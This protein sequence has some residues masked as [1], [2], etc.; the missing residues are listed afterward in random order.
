M[1]HSSQPRAVHLIKPDTPAPVEAPASSRQPTALESLLGELRSRPAARRGLISINLGSA[2]EAVWSNRTRSFLT[3][4][5]VIIGVASV[6]GALTLTQSVGGYINGL[7]SSLGSNAV[8]IQ[9]GGGRSI[10]GMGGP[11]G[12]PGGTRAPV[13]ANLTERDLQLLKQIPHVVAISPVVSS[14]A[15]VVYGGQNW[16]TRIM[17]A[18]PDIQ[19]IQGWDL[20]Q[21]LWFSEAE[22]SGGAAVAVIG[23][24]VAHNL[25]D[26]RSVNPIGQQIRIGNQLFRVVGVLAPKGVG[27]GGASDD[28]I[29]IPY[30]TAQSRFTNQ[31]AFLNIALQTDDRENVDQVV[32]NITI[33]LEQSHHIARGNPDDFSIITSAQLIQQANLGTA[34]FTLLLTGIAAIS[35]TVGGIGIMNIMLVSVTERTREIGIRMS[36]GAKRSDIRNQFL[37]EALF[38]S[39]LGALIGLLFGLLIGW[40]IISAIPLLVGGNAGSSVNI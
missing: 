20:A 5:G 3:V 26:S 27:I 2:L 15:Q 4:L 17:G 32:Q 1:N 28:S 35:L 9:S 8:Q 11:G 21:G 7:L 18:S 10:T 25:F 34:A 6:I 29:F 39:L 24:T 12:P 22:T 14:S 16:K 23:D 31:T 33:T 40:S 37:S 36:I 19:T 30:K 38:L 13:V